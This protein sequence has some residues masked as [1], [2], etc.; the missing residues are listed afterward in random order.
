M[1]ADVGCVSPIYIV[2][3]AKKEYIYYLDELLKFENI[4]LEFNKKSSGSVRQSLSFD[5]LCSI[6]INDI[7]DNILNDYNKK[8]NELDKIIYFYYNEIT[9]LQKLKQNYLLKFFQ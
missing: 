5:A 1:K 8:Y 7:E 6:E 2:F 3:K 4:K 9:K